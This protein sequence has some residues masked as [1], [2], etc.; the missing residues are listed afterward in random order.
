M[1]AF[2]AQDPTQGSGVFLATVEAFIEGLCPFE[3]KP[4]IVAVL[5]RVLCEDGSEY[6]LTLPTEAGAQRWVPV[7]G[8]AKKL[9]TTPESILPC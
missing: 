6:L 1:S 7:E 3:K 8:L 9:G 4:M 5:V 2:C